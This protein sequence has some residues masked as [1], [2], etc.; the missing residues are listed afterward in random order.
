M[1]YITLILLFFSPL[2]NAQDCKL[3]KE[4]D[5][6]TR[7]AK[8]SSGFISL[9]GASLSIEADNKEIDFFFAVRDKCFNDASTVFIYFE[10]SKIKTTY[11]N[12]G[13]MNCE[14]YF[15][16]IFKNGTTTPTV[17]KKLASQK[18]ASF[19]FTGNDKKATTVSLLPEQ[20]TDLMQITNC[21]IEESKALIK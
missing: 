2:L 11:R 10:G 3:I 19:I 4:T 16:F 5:P 20:Q 9:Q 14:G 17:L 21:I 13:S 8:I 18:V 15:H 1:K 7:V 6:Y 12:S